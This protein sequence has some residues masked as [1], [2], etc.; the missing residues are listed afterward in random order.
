MDI[1]ESLEIA[2]LAKSE[3]ETD[4]RALAAYALLLREIIKTTAAIVIA[5]TDED[6]ERVVKLEI[7]AKKL[8]IQTE[9]AETALSDRV[10]KMLEDE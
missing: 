8:A 9:E 10:K 6:I 5:M 7:Q 4:L 3:A 1:Q 2:L